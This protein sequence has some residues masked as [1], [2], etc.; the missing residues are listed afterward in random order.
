LA[1][2]DLLGFFGGCGLEA[3]F[4]AGALLAGLAV[5]VLVLA[6]FLDATDLCFTAGTVLAFF[7]DGLAAAAVLR[8][9]FTAAFFAALVFLAGEPAFPSPRRLAPRFDFAMSLALESCGDA[10]ACYSVVVPAGQPILWRARQAPFILGPTTALTRVLLFLIALYK[11]LLSPLLGARCRFHP[12]CSTY[13]RIAIARFGP[14]RGGLLAAWRILRCQPLCEGGLDPVPESFTLPR[15][16]S[17]G[18]H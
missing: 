16:R 17:H 13:A 7:T 6:T 1:A 14:L 2:R 11:R 8:A 10:T 5:R 18:E 15:C 3:F 12:S 4:A 9:G